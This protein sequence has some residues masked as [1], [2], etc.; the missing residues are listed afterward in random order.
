LKKLNIN[1]NLL[2]IVVINLALMIA[3]L[4]TFAFYIHHKTRDSYNEEVEYFQ[5]MN[6][7]MEKVT[8]N[9]LEGEQ[10]IC[11]VWSHYISSQ[12]MTM[13]E[14]YEFV[15][16][17]H[18]HAKVS[19]HLLYTDDGPFHG[20]TTRPDEGPG[21]ISVSYEGIDI[22]DDYTRHNNKEINITRAYPNPLNGVMSLSFFNELTFRD[23]DTGEDRSGLILR[24][25]PIEELEAKWVFPQESHD[26]TEYT[27]IDSE[28]RYIIKGSSFSGTDFYAFYTDTS[29]KNAIPT[30]QLRDRLLNSSGSF[31]LKDGT[32][33]ETLIA[34][35]PIIPTNGWTLLSY[36]DVDNLNHSRVN[37]GLPLLVSV[38]L[39]VLFCFDFMYM[40][41]FNKHLQ[42]MA[43]EA[44]RANQAKT[45]FLSTMS[46]DIRTPMNAIMGLTMIA[47]KNINDHEVVSDSLRK[48][49]MAGNHLVTLINDILDIS[50]I[51]SG[52]LNLSPSTFSIVELVS[53][54][55]NIS[56][57]MVK[58]K[59]LDFNFRINHMEKEYLYAD[60]LR[61][62]QIFI[63]ILTNAI[64][65]TEPGGSVSVSMKE[66]L[67]GKD[68][69]VRLIYEVSDTGIGMDEEY[70]KIMYEPF[71]RATDSRINTI[72]GTGLGLAIMHQ[73]VMLMEGSVDCKSKPGEGTTFTV[74]LDIPFSDRQVKEM[75]LPPMDVLLVDDDHM[76]LETTSAAL[77]SLGVHAET[78]DS[79]RGAI[80]MI[81]KRHNNGADYSVVIL[82]WRMP[83][84]DGLETI[85]MIRARNLSVPILLI[86]AYDWSDIEDQAKA[87]GANGFIS[88]PLFRSVIYD[89]ISSILSLQN[90]KVQPDDDHAEIAGM[91][92]LI[93]E[94]NDINWEIIKTILAMY[95]ITSERAVNGKVCLE[96][97]RAAAPGTYDLIFMDVQMPVM[98][99]LE[100][101]KAIRS[102][103]G[104]LSSIPII[105]MTADAFS[106]NITAC[107][108]A[109]MNGHIAKPV[110]VRLV[111][112]EI[113]KI[114]EGL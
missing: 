81:E 110:N 104:P 20:I 108:D 61:L 68:G 23:P 25:I 16:H 64:K 100:A 55:V 89:R 97:L 52:R 102:L 90:E 51:E 42:E 105:A 44:D 27:M 109:G 86:S 39:T 70:M 71:S 103:E 17:S 93:A 85:R 63:N 7:A 60:Q 67:S 29:K 72:Q 83:G 4:V 30:D 46:H 10:R 49:E 82:D 9:Y 6:V 84:T 33:K 12:R 40:V 94:D 26:S 36:I 106:E 19:A 69:C 45:D 91:N 37:W 18:V 43:A 2:R 77:E 28:G 76:V 59:N 5:S 113:H 56:Q 87:A 54:L 32:G 35:T 65:Y 15:S 8:E 74:V 57:P 114:K 79:G 13:E 31:T 47:G 66:E 21:D 53:N 48:I 62:N 95:G 14:A 78:A 75:S 34:H 99:G 1:M 41:R 38:I 96:K 112:K 111:L 101:T 11:D 3:I 107:F 73:M 98:N 92:I 88:K 50:K 24:V 80:D 58:E 22:F